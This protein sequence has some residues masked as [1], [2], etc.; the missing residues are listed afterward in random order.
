MVAVVWNA[1]LTLSNSLSIPQAKIVRALHNKCFDCGA[2]Q[3]CSLLS[4]EKGES[5]VMPSLVL[6]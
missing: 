2:V 3:V 6:A 5:G 4:G 1:P